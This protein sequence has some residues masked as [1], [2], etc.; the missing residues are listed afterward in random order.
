[1]ILT[2]LKCIFKRALNVMNMI[3]FFCENGVHLMM[4]TFGRGMFLDS[5]PYKSSGKLSLRLL[6]YLCMLNGINI[7]SRKTMRQNK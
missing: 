2:F 3:L 5:D 4:E 1:M 7:S 6:E